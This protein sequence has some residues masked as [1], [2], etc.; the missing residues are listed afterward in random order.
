MVDHKEKF[1]NAQSP[2][3]RARRNHQGQHG[4][5]SVDRGV[6]RIVDGGHNMQRRRAMARGGEAHTQGN[7]V[8]VHTRLPDVRHD[9]ENIDKGYCAC[10]VCGPNT[11]ARH[12]QHLSKV[13]YE[14]SHRRWLP[15]E[16]L[17]RYDTNVLRTQELEEAPARMVE[18]KHIQWI[19]LRVEYAQ[20]GGQLAAHGDPM[21]WSDVTRL[22]LLFTLPYWKVKIRKFLNTARY[23]GPFY[24]LYMAGQS[25]S[26]AIG[27]QN[28]SE[29][30][31]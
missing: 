23:C 22:P 1:H 9:G 25:R 28:G 6:K 16:H 11:S 20:S 24:M 2:N 13:V 31:H 4:C 5:F 19:F 7:V 30:G 17:Y 15:A 8:M 12:S 27:E 10:H 26:H 14:G 18:K 3:T 21:L 29:H